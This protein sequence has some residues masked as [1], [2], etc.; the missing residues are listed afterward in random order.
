MKSIIVSALLF[1]AASAQ[2]A[3]PTPP[4][5]PAEFGGSGTG[6]K[7]GSTADGNWAGWI[8]QVDGKP[9]PFWVGATKAYKIKHPNI[10]GLS[11]DKA[12]A[13]YWSEN[14]NAPDTAA[15]KRLRLAAM[16]QVQP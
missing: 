1:I 15:L 13:A 8:C 9:K 7:T 11:V 2:A 5:W 6:L 4:C 16:A 12:A 3:Q 10:S 14:V